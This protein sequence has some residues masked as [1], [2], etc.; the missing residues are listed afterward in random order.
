MRK[1]VYAVYHDCN[2]E[3]RSHELLECCRLMGE[4]HFVSYAA[5]VDIKDISMVFLTSAVNGIINGRYNGK[6]IIALTIGPFLSV[7]CYHGYLHAERIE[8]SNFTIHTANN[9]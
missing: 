3:A 5:P 4:V 1:I 6:S 2:F 8:I 7:F 9:S